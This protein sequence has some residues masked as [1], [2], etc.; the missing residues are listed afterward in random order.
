MQRQSPGGRDPVV[1]EFK[2]VLTSY[3]GIIVYQDEARARLPWTVGNGSR[4]WEGKVKPLAMLG[5]W[6]ESI[7]GH[8]LQPAPPPPSRWRP[9]PKK[10]QSPANENV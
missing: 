1:N 5:T 8:I 10:R 2:E 9:V 6:S 3:L 4:G 7:V